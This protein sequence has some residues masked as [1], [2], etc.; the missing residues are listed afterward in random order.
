MKRINKRV[1]MCTAMLAVAL[2]QG[3]TRSLAASTTEE[4]VA[5]IKFA[6]K[7]SNDEPGK[8][9]TKTVSWNHTGSYNLADMDC[10]ND[11]AYFYMFE[12]VPSA[13]KIMLS[14]EKDCDKKKKDWEFE[15]IT[16]KHPLTMD[17]WKRIS[18]L[19]GMVAGQIIVPG[20]KLTREDY[21]HGNI[22]GKLSC[23]TIDRP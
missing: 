19:K 16:Y 20:L 12:N 6:N 13:M 11:E 14:S 17:N 7:G 10:K 22:D 2:L 15:M 21:D 9:C 5:T 18:D 4:N 1:W 23:F 3:G 8:T